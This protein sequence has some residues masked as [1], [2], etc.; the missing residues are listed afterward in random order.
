[1]ESL[2]NYKIDHKCLNQIYGGVPVETRMEAEGL[3]DCL[4]DRNGN[5]KLDPGEC[6][7]IIDCAS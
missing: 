2:R 6:Q 5:G 7:E 3:C 4:D 1:M